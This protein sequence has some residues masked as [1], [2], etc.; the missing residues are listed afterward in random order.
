MSWLGLVGKNAVVTGGASGIGRATAVA[1]LEAGAN[2]TILDYNATAVD[3]VTEELSSSWPGLISGSSVD[4]SS[5][6]LVSTFW[7][8]RGPADIL[9][10]CAGITKD[11]WLTRMDESAWDDVINVN[12]KGTFLMTQGFARQRLATKTEEP[13]AGSVVNIASL[14]RY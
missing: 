12:L 2:V 6:S 14:V 5:G 3:K 9:C 13:Y 8:E 1:L 7:D 10:N 4:V 11:G